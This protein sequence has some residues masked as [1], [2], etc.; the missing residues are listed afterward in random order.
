MSI[1][2]EKMLIMV[3]S[4]HNNNKFYH[5]KL[6]DNDKLT[7][8]YGR[9]GAKVTE[10]VSFGG[11]DEFY[12]KLREKERKGYKETEII[13]DTNTNA[14][15]T[16][17]N[18]L[19][20][21]MKQIKADKESKEL[22]Q[23]LVEKNIHQIVSST[24]IT[25]D[26]KTGLFMTPLGAVTMN[27]ILRAKNLLSII[28]DMNNRNQNPIQYKE[29][30]FT[31]IPTKI[32]NVRDIYNMLN[33][34]DKINE[35]FDICDSLE[36]TLQLMKKP[37][38]SKIKKDNTVYFETSVKKL[39]NKK[40]FERINRYFEKSKNQKHGRTVNS[41]K[42]KNIYKVSIG[43]EAE[44]FEENLGNV[45]E[46]W[47]GTKVA[48][49]LSILK[50]G[51]LMPKQSPGQT[52]GYMFGKG[53]YFSDQSTKSLNYCD[54]LYWAGG[55]KEDKIYLFL[56]DVAMGKYQV[57]SSYGSNRKPSAGYDS[58]FAQPGRSGVM[59]NEMIVFR[60]SQI[61][62]KYILEIERK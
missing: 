1:L 54:G 42:I 26:K 7:I 6:E 16:N 11:Y 48:N 45:M 55:N 29:E 60:K 52:T 20:I 58:F 5:L 21:A 59:N 15:V 53:L 33:T 36:Q 32:N 34:Q 3:N 56:A 31:I 23:R 37:T 41:L 25:F 24:S 35:Q 38:K 18:L 43:N 12:K 4:N 30:Y 28:A 40:E 44:V 62:L 9:V 10:R 57:P 46:L 17:D 19:D 39:K 13:T 47:H 22:I 49:M 27:G 51:L 61:K 8:R 50:S 14:T 2:E